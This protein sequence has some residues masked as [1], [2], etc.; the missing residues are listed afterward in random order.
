MSYCLLFQLNIRPATRTF[1][2]LVVL[3][4]ITAC[5][6]DSTASIPSSTQS[7]AVAATEISEPTAVPAPTPTAGLTPAPPATP[8]SLPTD[9]PAANPTPKPNIPPSAV[10]TPVQNL[11]LGLAWTAGGFDDF[12]GR[13]IIAL[14]ALADLN[15]EQAQFLAGAGWVSDGITGDEATAIETFTDISMADVELGTALTHLDWL[16]E[17][18]APV[19]IK[20]S[21]LQAFLDLSSFPDASRS[22]TGLPWVSDSPTSTGLRVLNDLAV[23]AGTD[24]GLLDGLVVVPWFQDDITAD[25]A[26]AVDALAA[27]DATMAEKLL[28]LDWFSDDVTDAEAAAIAGISSIFVG[29]PELASTLL[30]LGWVRDGITSPEGAVFSLLADMEP[31]IASLVSTIPWFADGVTEGHETSALKAL[32][33]YGGDYLSLGVQIAGMAFYRDSAEGHDTSAVNALRTLSDDPED[34]ALLTKQ[35]WYKDGINDEEA[36]L[37]TVLPGQAETVPT[38][39]QSLVNNMF[40]IEATTVPLPL[41]GEIKLY[42]VR[43]LPHPVESATMAHLRMSMPVIEELMGFPLPVDEIIILFSTNIEAGGINYGTHFTLDLSRDIGLPQFETGGI[44]HEIG[45]FYRVARSAWFGEGT[46]NFLATLVANELYSQPV[47][48]RAILSNCP[49]DVSNITEIAEAHP[50]YY[51]GPIEYRFCYHSYGE[52]IIRDTENVMGAGPFKEA[53]QEIFRR[54]VEE[55]VGFT[56]SE[57]YQLFIDHTPAEKVAAVKQVF[58]RFHGGG[59]LE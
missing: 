46:A 45:H 22:I 35:P 32:A 6:A 29:N 25:E 37:L 3:S 34:S 7:S 9:T 57:I 24:S 51:P 54:G 5:G 39:Y 59:F 11:F 40:Y 31:P 1:V 21:W 48:S 14:K 15:L 52:K 53:W 20:L 27:L 17:P 23:I 10:P 55:G 26:S 43:F 50:G 4:V 44:V 18:F 49:G 19:S 33:S 41:S 47:A 42:I 12:E 28:E 56:D 8:T 38:D 16:R 2:V 58:V 36:V 13:A 30:D